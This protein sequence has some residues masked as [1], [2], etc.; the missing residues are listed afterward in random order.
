MAFTRRNFLCI[1]TSCNVSPLS[2][3]HLSCCSHTRLGSLITCIYEGVR[4]ASLSEEP[5]IDITE[6]LNADIVLTTYDVLKEDLTHDF[7]RHD[8]DRH[9]LRFQKRCD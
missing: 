7:D 5:M 2:F 4:N 1:S 3:F 8:G 6:L 9:C